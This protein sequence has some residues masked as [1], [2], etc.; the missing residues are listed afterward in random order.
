MA[1]FVSACK[2][3]LPLERHL[4]LFGRFKRNP[5]M[6]ALVFGRRV[7]RPTLDPCHCVDW[8][9]HLQNVVLQSRRNMEQSQTI[10]WMG[11]ILHHFE[12]MGNPLFIGIYR[13]ITNPGFLK[14]CLGCPA[15][16]WSWAGQLPRP[17]ERQAGCQAGA[18]VSLLLFGPSA[19]VA[20]RGCSMKTTRTH[21]FIVIL[22][23]RLMLSQRGCL[24]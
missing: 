7:P 12:T 11:D 20:Q 1:P 4:Q 13:G 24:S 16:C 10:L 2:K 3:D 15:P 8:G 18:A 21:M 14:S 23:E 6:D 19:T 9:L 17:L 5:P 22:R